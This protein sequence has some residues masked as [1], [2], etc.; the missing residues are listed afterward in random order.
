MATASTCS[1]E[2]LTWAFLDAEGAVGVLGP[3]VVFQLEGGGVVDERL[4][5]LGH[6]RSAVV[7]IGAGLQRAHSRSQPRGTMSD[8]ERRKGAKKAGEVRRGG[9]GAVSLT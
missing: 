3:G 2:R 8:G 9:G 5:A 1:L 6:A 7:E 4:R